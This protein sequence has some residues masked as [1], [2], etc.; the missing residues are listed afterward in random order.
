VFPF[1][2]GISVVAP[3]GI[4]ASQWQTGTA[5]SWLSTAGTKTVRIQKESAPGSGVWTDSYSASI[6]TGNETQLSGYTEDGSYRIRFE[7]QGVPSAWVT[8]TTPDAFLGTPSAPSSH[9]F[10]N[11]GFI[12]SCSVTPGEVDCPLEYEWLNGAITVGGG[13]DVSDAVGSEMSFN[14]PT[15]DP[16]NPNGFRARHTRLGLVS[17]W[18]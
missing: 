3:S 11:N 5:V 16:A 13:S 8:F 2:A 10:A 9:G 1:F 15:S 18:G 6:T 14:L 12:A 4:L 17:D 7:R